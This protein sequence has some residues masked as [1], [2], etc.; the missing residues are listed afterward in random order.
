MTQADGTQA[1]T[2]TDQHTIGT[3]T[4][5]NGTKDTWRFETHM[6]GRHWYWETSWMKRRQGE[7]WRVRLTDTEG[8]PID[9]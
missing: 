6:E 7:R 1:E 5:R 3:V 2:Q 4:Y 8:N 9:V